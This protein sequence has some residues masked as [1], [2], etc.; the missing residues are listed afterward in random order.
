[1]T[2]MKAWRQAEGGKATWN[3]LNSTLYYNG[4]TVYNRFKVRNYK[5]REDGIKANI[6]TLKLPKYSKIIEGLKNITNLQDAYKLAV[7]LSDGPTNGPFY[8]WSLG[9]YDRI[10]ILCARN[11]A[12]Y[13]CPPPKSVRNSYIANVLNFWIKTNKIVFNNFI[14]K[15]A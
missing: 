13:I 10:L 6:T 1:M 4:S 9:Y 12:G 7:T 3:L 2:F 14:R 11:K 15:P 5:N 8:V